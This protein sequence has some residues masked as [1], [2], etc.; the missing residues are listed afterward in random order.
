MRPALLGLALHHIEHLDSEQAQLITSYTHARARISSRD[1]TGKKVGKLAI[2]MR[3]TLKIISLRVEELTKLYLVVWSSISS[4][5][6][7]SEP[8]HSVWGRIAMQEGSTLLGKS[9]N[10]SDLRQTLQTIE[11]NKEG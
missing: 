2:H 10:S 5:E 1:V 7:L 11:I 4:G 3:S 9:F 6:E 8:A